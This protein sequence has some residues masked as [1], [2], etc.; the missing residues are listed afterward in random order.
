[1]I[2]S[3]LPQSVIDELKV[4]VEKKGLLEE[5]RQEI[6]KLRS[7]FSQ[8]VNE[9][10]VKHLASS[11]PKEKEEYIKEAERLYQEYEGKI[12]DLII[13]SKNV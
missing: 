6:E 1:M 5:I 13:R 2:N 3:S 7:E 8:K 11:S 10:K 4:L 12:K 9:L